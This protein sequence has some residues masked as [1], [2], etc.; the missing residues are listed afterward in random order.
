MKTALPDITIDASRE[1]YRLAREFQIRV[2][3]GQVGN[4]WKYSGAAAGDEMDIRRRWQGF[5]GGRQVA[6]L[7]HM[8]WHEGDPGSWDNRGDYGDVGDLD[9]RTRSRPWYELSIRTMDWRPAMLVKP[10]R[11]WLIDADDWHVVP[12]LYL[13]GFHFPWFVRRHGKKLPGHDV[14]VLQ[15]S[16]LIGSEYLV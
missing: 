11:D 8:P 5:V 15:D 14:Y 16:A 1:C 10:E 7:L 2:T 9:L 4:T 13:H 3:S 6:A 12:P